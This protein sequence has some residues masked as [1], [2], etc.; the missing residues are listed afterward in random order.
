MLKKIKY[1]IYLKAAIEERGLKLAWIAAKI[2]IDP[3][4]LT[5]IIS[6]RRTATK[7]QKENLAEL[8]ECSVSDLFKN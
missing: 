2:G 6:G 8:F 5:N 1:N 4:L 3:G 7:A